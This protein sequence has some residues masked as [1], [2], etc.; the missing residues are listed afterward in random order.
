MEKI[1]VEKPNADKVSEMG[2]RSWP[3]WFKGVSKFDW[4]YGEKETCYILEGA[5][6]VTPEGEEAVSFEKGDLVVFSQGL[7]CVWSISRPIKKHYRMG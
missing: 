3:I 7:N 5:A 1:I 4:H 6:T 2:I